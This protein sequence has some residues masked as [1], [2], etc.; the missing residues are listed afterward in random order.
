MVGRPHNK[1]IQILE[2][3]EKNNLE[4]LK[5]IYKSLDMEKLM[6]FDEN[7]KILTKFLKDQIENK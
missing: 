7:N 6:I 2:F 3:L 4:N 1:I 5:K